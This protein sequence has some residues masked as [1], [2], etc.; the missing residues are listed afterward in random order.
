MAQIEQLCQRDDASQMIAEL[1][2]KLDSVTRLSA[3]TDPGHLH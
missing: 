2:R 1:L 3:W